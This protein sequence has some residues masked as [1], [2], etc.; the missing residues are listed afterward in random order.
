MAAKKIAVTVCASC[1]GVDGNSMKPTIPKLAGLQRMYL[2]KQMRDYVAGKRTNGS[3]TPCGPQLNPNDIIGLADY[4]N[5]Q[6][7]AAGKAGDLALVAEGKKIYEL[8]NSASDVDDCQE[9]HKPAGIGGSGLYPRL[10]GQPAEYTLKQMR[11][12]QTRARHNDKDEVMHDVAENM[13]EREMRAVAEYLAG[14]Q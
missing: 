5:G 10:S 12:F 13:T 1:H 14:L 7:P 2:V 8:G 3:E 4:F 6:K 11:D 9:C